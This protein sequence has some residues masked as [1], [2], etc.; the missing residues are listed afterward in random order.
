[1]P[2][3]TTVGGR[4]AADLR[5]LGAVPPRHRWLALLNPAPGARRLT[6][7]WRVG[8]LA[9]ALP[10]LA[11]DLVADVDRRLA[12]VPAPG[13]LSPAA[14]ADELRW[15]RRTLVSLHAQEA[16]AGALLRQPSTSR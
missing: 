15:T 8:R 10:G 5:L 4:A 14:L 7:A 6:A 2:V 11:T 3:V 12:E 1:A 9:A 16:L 13:D